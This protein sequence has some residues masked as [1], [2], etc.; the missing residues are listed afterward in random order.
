M[1]ARQPD[2]SHGGGRSIAG[3]DLEVNNIFF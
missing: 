1:P 3:R 2:G